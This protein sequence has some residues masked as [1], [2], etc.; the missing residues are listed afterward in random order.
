MYKRQDNSSPY[1][2]KKNDSSKRGALSLWTALYDYEA[3]GEDELSL[4]R[5]EIVEVLSMDSKISGDEGWWT[6]KIGG[7]VG[8]FPANFVA[9]EN[10][11]DRVSNAIADI[12]PIEIDFS[13]LVLEEV[14]GVGA[15]SYTHLDVYKRQ[16][17]H[18]HFSENDFY[19][20][21]P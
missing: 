2:F 4:R 3:Q 6:G 17:T 14:I 11:M 16:H 10:I 21:V 12:Q 8:I 18:R 7:K 20:H 15:V 13:E 1:Y 9:E 5:G 19:F